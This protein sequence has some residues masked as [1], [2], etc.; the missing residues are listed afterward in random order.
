ME[1]LIRFSTIYL[2]G[3]QVK[4]K[5]KV[6]L[7]D[8]ISKHNYKINEFIIFSNVF[9][10]FYKEFQNNIEMNDSP[11]IKSDHFSGIFMFVLL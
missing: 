10:D 7:T 5:F 4:L 2:H 6:K 3:H 8:S 9:N 1:A 11:D